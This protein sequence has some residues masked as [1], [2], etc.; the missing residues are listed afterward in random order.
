MAKPILVV[1]DDPDLRAGISD[2]LKAEGYDVTVAQDGREGWD[3]L[4][5]LPGT[6]LILLDYTMPHL[7]AR[8]FRDLQRTVPH[9]Y[10]IPVVLFSA[11][12]LTESMISALS[13]AAVLRKP[14]DIEDLLEMV[15]RFAA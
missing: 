5:K 1:E 6:G 15:A 7:D 9:L 14:V 12:V 11:A 3:I 4:Q 2:L 13:P 10:S 8:G